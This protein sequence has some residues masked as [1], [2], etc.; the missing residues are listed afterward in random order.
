MLRPVAQ[1]RWF[2]YAITVLIIAGGFLWWQVERDAIDAD[3]ASAT[4]F[5]IYVS[6]KPPTQNSTT[7]LTGSND[8]DTSKWLTFR[9]E[10]YGF[11]L[12][13]KLKPDYSNGD[14][15]IVY[16][17][18][19]GIIYGDEYDIGYADSL[20][21]YWQYIVVHLI[22]DPKDFL[23]FNYDI[24]EDSADAVT[25]S[26]DNQQF[27][28]S[29]NN[30]PALPKN[31][32]NKQGISSYVFSTGRHAGESETV[33]ITDKGFIEISGFPYEIVFNDPKSVHSTTFSIVKPSQ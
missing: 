5:L 23:I 29:S 11:T 33:Y 8:F 16:D 28:I 9:N 31:N 12:S 32:I 21:Y 4:D 2:I 24:N 20:D 19:K 1:N 25:Y 13:Y 14:P 10:K 27:I 18:Q 6:K 22:D 17:S 15:L 26:K 30:N 3:T 7:S